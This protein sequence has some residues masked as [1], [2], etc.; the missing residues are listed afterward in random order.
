MSSTAVADAVPAASEEGLFYRVL[1]RFIHW[2]LLPRTYVE[3]G[4]AKGASL[5]LVTPVTRAI[6]VDPDPQLDGPVGTNVV[7]LRQTSDDF[8]ARADLRD[9]LGGNP[10]D[11]AF[12]DGMHLF[13]CALREVIALE[14]VASP[15]STILIHDCCPVDPSEASRD[16]STIRWAGDVWKTV[17]A[18]REYRPDLQV[19]TLGAAPTGLAVVRGLDPESTVLGSA[20]DEIVAR[21]QDRDLSYLH[22]GPGAVERLNWRPVTPRTVATLWPDAPMQPRRMSLRVARMRDEG[23]A[24]ARWLGQRAIR[25]ARRRIEAPT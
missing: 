15:T 10:V 6:G 7:V 14:R 19:T 21:Y 5:R 20:Y 23:P 12:V 11:L 1:L 22:R 18:L 3:I 25:G 24:R 2:H 4:V 8:F 9:L 13:E 17:V 16:R